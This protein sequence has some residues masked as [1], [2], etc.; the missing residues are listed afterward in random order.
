MG[1]VSCDS[2]VNV[3]DAL[4]VLQFEVGLRVDSGCPL[5]PDTLY[6][7]ACDVSADELCNV[8]DALFILQCE[9]GIPNTFCPAAVDAAVQAG[10]FTGL[11]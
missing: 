1:D 8:V 6:L 4:F 11:P 5:A 3:V 10:S 7:A 2:A 9:V